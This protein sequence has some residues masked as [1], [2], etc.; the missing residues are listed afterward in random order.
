M[1]KEKKKYKVL[2]EVE[3]TE[4]QLS[5]LIVT[6]FE[7]GIGYWAMLWNDTPE[8]DA[9]REA[10]MYAS[11]AVW[12]II[13]NGGSVILTDAEEDP[14]TAEQW[15]LTLEKFLNGIA[16]N[17]ALRQHDCDLDN[18]DA[19]TADCIIQYALFKDII[20]G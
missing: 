13:S 11:Q 4:E 20:Y 18:A 3:Y 5:D 12:H 17:S 15:E 6:A 8:F 10:G 2:Q 14:E 7:G 1:E 19:V 16:L 9:A